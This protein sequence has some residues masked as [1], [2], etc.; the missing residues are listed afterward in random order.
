M[1]K[2]LEPRAQ[3]A[4]FHTS[5]SSTRAPEYRN[6]AHRLR[7][8]D[9]W[10]VQIGRGKQGAYSTISYNVAERTARRIFMEIYVQHDTRVR[11]MKN[12]EVI[13]KRYRK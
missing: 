3:R 12:F 2:K 8:K 1:S 4:V 10:Y 11:L 7:D 6:A 9:V 5:V 13:E